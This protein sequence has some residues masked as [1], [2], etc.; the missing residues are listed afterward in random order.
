MNERKAPAARARAPGAVNE[1]GGSQEETTALG[2]DSGYEA[3]EARD[4]DG[5]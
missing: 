3:E 5:D 2:S 4:E 1:E